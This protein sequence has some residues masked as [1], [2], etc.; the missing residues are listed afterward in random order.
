M[1]RVLY[2]RLTP[3]TMSTECD[4]C[5]RP[6]SILFE[7]HGVVED[8][9]FGNVFVFCGECNGFWLM[10]EERGYAAIQFMAEVLA[11]REGCGSIFLHYTE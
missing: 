1:E 11:Q 4:A 3:G 7:P 10:W 5:E 2:A 9:L 8:T 6:L